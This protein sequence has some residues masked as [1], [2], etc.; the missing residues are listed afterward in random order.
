[1]SDEPKKPDVKGWG[2][3]EWGAVALLAYLWSWLLLWHFADALPI[4]TPLAW[5]AF[6]VY[7]PI[8]IV[9]RL[10]LWIQWHL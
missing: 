2:R 6:V 1:V 3:C 9:G 10:I 8:L 4:S 5:I 7:W